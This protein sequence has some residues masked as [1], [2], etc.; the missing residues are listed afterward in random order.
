LIVAKAK[1]KTIQDKY[2]LASNAPV[3]PLSAEQDAELI[4]AEK[5]LLVANSKVQELSASLNSLIGLP[6]D[7]ELDLVAPT[8]FAEAVSLAVATNQA[9]ATNPEVVEAEQTAIKA[10]AGRKLAK[11]DYVPDVAVLGGYAYQTAV[12]LLPND[13]SYVGVMATF[14]IFDSGKREHTL[15]MRDA[16]VEMA[17]LA[18]VL[19]KAKVAATVKTSYFEMER[20]RLLSQL[21]QRIVSSSLVV[22]A[23]YQ[24]NSS[25]VIETRAKSEA[26]MFGAELSYREAYARLKTLMGDN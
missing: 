26:D 25:E 19:T 7:T 11:L 13:F 17:E 20:S 6:E 18:V 23:A 8:P 16:Q 15:K 2:V 1:A 5:T 12:P 4:G 24:A 21:S 22:N 14:T 10:R 3:E 9:M